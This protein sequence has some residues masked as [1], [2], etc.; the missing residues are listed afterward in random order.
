M[1]RKQADTL[2]TL[3]GKLHNAGFVVIPFHNLREC[4]EIESVANVSL[5]PLCNLLEG[6]TEHYQYSRRVA[7]QLI[8]FH[9][10]AKWFP[11]TQRGLAE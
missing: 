2:D 7:D 3:L 6:E 5:A 1:K 9:I 8:N 10:I 4:R 11:E